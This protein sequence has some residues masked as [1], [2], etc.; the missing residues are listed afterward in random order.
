[1]RQ[2][3]SHGIRTKMNS[4]D[5]AIH[6]GPND[7]GASALSIT[8][9]VISILGVSWLFGAAYGVLANFLEKKNKKG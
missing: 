3:N 5:N 9:V 4:F 6:Y 8:L 1:M 2:I 7:A